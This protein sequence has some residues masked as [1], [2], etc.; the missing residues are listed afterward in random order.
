MSIIK[1]LTIGCI[2]VYAAVIGNMLVRPKKTAS[3]D[4]YILQPVG[5]TVAMGVC[6]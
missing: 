3:L 5:C 6:V 4:H 2:C 1:L